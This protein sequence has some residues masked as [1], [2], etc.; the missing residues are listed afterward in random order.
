ME[1]FQLSRERAREKLRIADHILNSTFPLVK[2]PRL[3]VGVMDNIFLALTNAMSSVVYY[4]RLFK[5]I[6]NFKDDFNDKFDMFKERI[7]RRYNLNIEYVMLIQ[8]IKNLI[9]EHKKSPVEFSRG[10][11]FVIC[12][13]GYRCKS[14][15]IRDMKKFISKSKQFIQEVNNI[16]SKNERIFR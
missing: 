15:S 2:D 3:L 4:E 12:T 9:L 5:R 8:D 13:N 16:V 7:V 6:P 1:Q 11:S 14:I 10:D